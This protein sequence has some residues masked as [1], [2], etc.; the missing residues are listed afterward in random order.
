M[1][2][3]VNLWVRVGALGAAAVLLITAC[4]PDDVGSDPA[5]AQQSTEAPSASD[6]DDETG[7]PSADPQTTEAETDAQPRMAPDEDGFLR[8]TTLPESVAEQVIELPAEGTEDRMATAKAQ[9]ISLDSDGEYARLVVAWLRKDGGEAV[10][11]NVTSPFFGPVN[12]QAILPLS[13]PRGR[14]A[15]RTAVCRQLLL[16]LG[17]PRRW[18]FRLAV[19]RGPFRRRRAQ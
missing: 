1:T 11:P 19:A 18:N 6:S 4:A 9:V 7:A 17:R 8:A 3:T 5:E 10:A 16:C 13:R 15:D 14:R 12:V 2:S